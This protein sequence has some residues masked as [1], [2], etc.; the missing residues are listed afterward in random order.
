TAAGRPK[1]LLE[2]G[3]PICTPGGANGKTGVIGVVALEVDGASILIGGDAAATV[4]TVGI[5]RIRGGTTIRA[6]LRHIV[7]LSSIEATGVGGAVA[8]LAGIPGHPSGHG[9]GDNTVGAG[10]FV[11][12][13][14]IVGRRWSEFILKIPVW[15]GVHI[16]LPVVARCV[17]AAPAP[18][19]Q[20]DLCGK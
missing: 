18:D 7:V 17:V 4:G 12:G 6:R 13:D 10:S 5:V 20:V 15:I 19:G 1:G 14:K 16:V 3:D 9:Q 8:R 11:L 2:M